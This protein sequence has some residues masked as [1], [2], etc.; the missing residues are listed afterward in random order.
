MNAP[1]KNAIASALEAVSPEQHAAA[2]KAGAAWAKQDQLAVEILED[3]SRALGAKCTRLQYTTLMG[4]WKEG[5]MSQNQGK[6]SAAAD[7]AWDRFKGRLEDLFEIEIITPESE[8]PIA[9][10]RKAEREAKKAEL[11]AKHAN[12][13]PDQLRQKIEQTYSALA[14]NPTSKD[15]KKTLKDL[16]TVLVERTSEENKANGEALRALRSQVKEAAN[17]CTDS[18]TLQ[19]ALD[20]LAGEAD[21]AY[22]EQK[23][24]EELAAMGLEK[25]RTWADHGISDADL[26]TSFNI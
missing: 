25:K 16:E 2:K 21:F 19:A 6:T 14:K 26:K 13:G 23:E 24:A 11:L 9:Q 1:Q 17:K 4:D 22:A 20:I 15:L 5:W 18:D 7:K 8:N 10:K 12:T 3:Y